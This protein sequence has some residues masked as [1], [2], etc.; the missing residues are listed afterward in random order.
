VE[1][2]ELPTVDAEETELQTVDGTLVEEI[3]LPTVD[4]EETELPMVEA[5]TCSVFATLIPGA[6]LGPTDGM[7]NSPVATSPNWKGIKK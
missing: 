4:A 1:E 5:S 7:E 3:E 2:I 6:F